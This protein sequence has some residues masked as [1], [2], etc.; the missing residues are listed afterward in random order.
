MAV[1]R[2]GEAV[3]VPA[4]ALALGLSLPLS[5]GLTA[6]SGS[7]SDGGSGNASSAA[8]KAA[9]AAASAVSKAASAA[10]SLAS[11]GQNAF[12]S[13]T[14]EA[15]RRLDEVKNGVNAKDDVTLGTVRTTSDGRTTVS[16][17][18]RNT[19]DSTKSFAVQVNFKNSGGNLLDTVV[20]TF[21]DVAAAHTA[22]G[23]AR[24]THNLSGQVKPEVGTALRY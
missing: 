18:V 11:Q 6:C 1:N 17:A 15:K 21:T 4:L 20:I 9:S 7:D 13:A 12:A 5:L 16:V 14:A 19:A 10:S 23:T 8:S 2:R 22:N 3:K 24:S